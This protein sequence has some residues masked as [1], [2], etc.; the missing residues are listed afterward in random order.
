M[1][2]IIRKQGYLRFLKRCIP[3][4]VVTYW[5]PVFMSFVAS[6]TVLIALHIHWSLSVVWSSA[7]A[8][9][10]YRSVIVAVLCPDSRLTV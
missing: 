7:F 3:S 8:M 6:F 1:S 5:K 10:M 9:Y 4:I 2:S